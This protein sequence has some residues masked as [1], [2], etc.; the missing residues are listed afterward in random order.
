M[1][2]HTP[3]GR[4][5]TIKGNATSKPTPGGQLFL[6]T[7]GTLDPLLTRVVLTTTYDV[8]ACARSYELI[9]K[10]FGLTR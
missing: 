6:N 10:A 5:A 7:Y 2:L 3:N 4:Q 1:E 8:A 9:A